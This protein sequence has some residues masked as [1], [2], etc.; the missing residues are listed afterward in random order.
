[1]KYHLWIAVISLSVVITACGPNKPAY[2]N[3][4]VESRPEVGTAPTA[5]NPAAKAAQEVQQSQ[6]QGGEAAQKPK[7]EMPPFFDSQKNEIKDLPNYSKAKLVNAQVGDFNGSPTM[8]M[9]YSLRGTIEEAVAFYEKQIKA[10]GWQVVTSSKTAEYYEWALKKGEREQLIINIKR[11]PQQ[12]AY[13][14]LM[15]NRNQAPLAK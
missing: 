4:K 3:V 11:D 6:Q 2:E 13:L 1:M 10:N 7:F 9:M 15:I 14:V 5:E 12:P 8:I